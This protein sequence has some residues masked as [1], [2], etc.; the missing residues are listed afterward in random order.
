MRHF[1]LVLGGLALSGF[2]SGCA[3]ETLST[4]TGFLVFSTVYSNVYVRYAAIE[5][6]LP[7]EVHGNPT[8]MPKPDFDALVE[9]SAA[10]RSGSPPHACC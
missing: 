9:R 8:A 3:P 5:G 2:L 7:L 6:V 1:L 4:R 10:I